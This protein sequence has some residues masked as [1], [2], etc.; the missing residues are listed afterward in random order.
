MYVNKKISEGRRSKN[1][2]MFIKIRDWEIGKGFSKKCL[3][4]YKICK[5][6]LR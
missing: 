5:L 6:V 2:N 1:D 3:K 4:V